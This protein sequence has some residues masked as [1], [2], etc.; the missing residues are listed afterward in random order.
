MKRELALRILS[1]VMRWDDERAVSEFGWLS[2]MSRVKYDGY[3]DYLAGSR[4]VESL[5]HWL[6]QFDDSERETA[7]AFV[8]QNLVYIGATEMQHLVELAY[9]EHI[10]PALL[11]LA[12]HR[13]DVPTYRIWAHPD[14]VDTFSNLLR[15]TLFLG[16]SDGARI[17]AFR[18]AN[19]GVI[20]N[21]QVV[22]TTDVGEAK[23][24]SL[25]KALRSD[26]HDASARFS[27]VF[28][29]DDFVGTGLT[30]LR[31]EDGQWAGKLPKFMDAI[32]SNLSEFFECNSTVFVH[33]YI[34]THQAS[35]QLNVRCRLFSS[36]MPIE[37]QIPKVQLSYGYILPSDIVI[38]CERQVEFLR[39]VDRYYDPT[40][41][42]QHT[43]V[44]GADVR[45]GFGDCALPLVLEHNTPNNSIAL[46]W[47]ETSG[48]HGYP[49]MR[50]LFRRRQRHQ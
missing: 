23:W 20:S 32:S 27:C 42:T 40:I 30:L 3:H 18:R 13:I 39:L 12:A 21:E 6:Q 36:A 38:D 37:T 9:P 7:Y 47:A 43:R 28:L 46:I 50:P 24:K 8:R 44:G 49:A 48:S 1:E 5:V 2:I 4:F 22:G 33:H 26:T 25:L 34:G 41:E 45:L 19:E 16:L 15:G 14:T 10:Q 29:L 35:E 11:E 17:D 31:Q